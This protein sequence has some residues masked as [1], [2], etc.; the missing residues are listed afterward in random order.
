MDHRS[1][2]MFSQTQQQPTDMA[3]ADLQPPSTFDLR[4]LLLLH[5]V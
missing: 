4:D 1:V 5:V 3:L 2:A